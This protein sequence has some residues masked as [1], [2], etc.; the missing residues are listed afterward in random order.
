MNFEDFLKERHAD[1]YIGTDDDMS[2]DFDRFL[3]NLQID[4][5]IKLADEWTGKVV[6]FAQFKVKQIKGVYSAHDALT[7]VDNV[8]SNLIK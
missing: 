1:N 7:E 8:L 4:E 5:T 2:D 6:S 3:E